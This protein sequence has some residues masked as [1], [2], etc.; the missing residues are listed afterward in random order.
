MPQ[1]KLLIIDDE[2]DIRLL[3]KR[4]LKLEGYDVD[5]AATGREGLAKALSGTYDVVVCDVRLPDANGIELTAKIKEGQPATEIIQLTANGSIADGVAAV[6]GGAFDYLTKGDNNNR[7]LPLVERAAEKAQAQHRLSRIDAERTARYGFDRI[8]GRSPAIETSK[9]L[10]Q[11]V[12][13]TDATVLVTGPTGTGKEVF[14]NAIHY[15]SARR[16]EPLLAVNCAAFSRELLESEM[17]GHVAGAFTG[18]TKTKKGLFEEADGGTIFLDELGEMDLG[19][20]ARLL[21]I[22]ENGSFMKVGSTTEQRA[23]VRIVAATNRDLLAEA[24]AGNFRADLYYRLSTFVVDLPALVERPEDIQPLA[25]YFVETLAPSVNP[26]VRGMDRDF[27]QGLLR[28]TWRGNVRE[29]RNFIERALILARGNELGAADLPADLGQPAVSSESGAGLSAG[30]P[31]NPG[32]AAWPVGTSLAAL[33][34]LHIARVMDAVAG[35]K[36]RAAE[37]LGIGLSTLYRKLEQK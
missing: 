9:R 21:R 24:E 37:I 6:K 11:Q 32:K 4:I 13:G 3:L 30:M 2:D 28:M 17:F 34:Q 22:L 26:Q 25:K 18:A 31:T 23:D 1:A 35:N 8:I 15:A 12:A 33:E 20:Q 5:V 16:S 36:S 27:E 29:L 10:A 7:L 19:L 14:A